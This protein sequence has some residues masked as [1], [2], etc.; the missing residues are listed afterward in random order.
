[1]K[2]NLWKK[3]EGRGTH[4]TSQSDWNVFKYNIQRGEVK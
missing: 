2:L 4:D 3:E 1:M